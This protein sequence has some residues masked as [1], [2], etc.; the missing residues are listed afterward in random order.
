MKRNVAANISLLGVCIFLILSVSMGIHQYS[1]ARQNVV[2]DL[3]TAL[4]RAVKKHAS[5]WLRTDTI[6]SYVHLQEVMGSPVTIHTFDKD[7]AEALGIRK[8]KD[9][10][11][12]QVRL[13]GLHTAVTDKLADGYVMSDTI[14]WMS[15]SAQEMATT[16]PMFSFRG[17]AYCPTMTILSISDQTLPIVCFILAI[18]FGV[19]AFFFQ[20]RTRAEMEKQGKDII[21]YGDLSLCCNDSCICNSQQQRI[22]LT[23]LEYRLLEMFYR[24]PK[25]LLQKEEICST[26]WPKKEDANETLYTLIRRLKKIIEEHSRLRI[27]ADRGRAYSLEELMEE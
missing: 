16:A 18:G 11:G 27:V 20:R 12:V 7:F 22:K 8:L 14:L 4:Q 6:Q 1:V 3:N 19:A 2:A 21:T 13:A 9:V 26:L 25:H 23:P 5:Q 10:S 17:F 24:S 15:S